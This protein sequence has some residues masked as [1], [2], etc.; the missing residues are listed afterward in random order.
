MYF[1]QSRGSPEHHDDDAAPRQE[2]PGSR[3]TRDEVVREL[4]KEGFLRH[5]AE[6]V[7]DAMLQA[8][9]ENARRG[10]GGS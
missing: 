8:E 2:E 6:A 7:H 4:M 3:V 10:S 5:E 9:R 1:E